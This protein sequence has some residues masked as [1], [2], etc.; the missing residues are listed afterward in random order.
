MIQKMIENSVNG[1]NEVNNSVEDIRLSYLAKY[2]I[3]DVHFSCQPDAIRKIKEAI[4]CIISRFNVRNDLRTY[5]QYFHLDD[6]E[7]TNFKK[8]TTY[9][10]D[11]LILTK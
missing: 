5:D 3:N 9:I 6:D 11:K 7:Y 2:P 1:F 10:Q 8:W 4:K